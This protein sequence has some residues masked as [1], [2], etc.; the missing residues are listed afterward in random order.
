M[1]GASSSL[2]VVWSLSHVQLFATPW[3]EAHQ[4][5]LSFTISLSLHKLMS[6][7]SVMLSNH[8]ILYRP[9]S[10]CPQCFPASGSALEELIISG[11]PARKNESQCW[12]HSQGAVLGLS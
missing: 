2:H 7:E 5:S 8:L 1:C 6:V 12:T 3:T 4:A 11:K 10:S 9:F